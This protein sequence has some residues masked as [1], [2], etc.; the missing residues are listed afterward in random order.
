MKFA[1]D[2]IS[3]DITYMWNLK[4]D[5]NELIHKADTNS[6]TEKQTY[7]YQRGKIGRIS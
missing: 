2:K 4:M 6:Q 1:K 3:Y 5:I 7:V